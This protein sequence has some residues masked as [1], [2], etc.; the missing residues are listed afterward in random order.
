MRKFLLPVCMMALVVFATGAQ[1]ATNHAGVKLGMAIQDLGGDG[2]ESIDV[3]SR[4]GFVGGAY[5]QSDLSRNF[6]IRLEALYYMKGATGDSADIDVTVKLDYV[7]LP[8]LLMAHVPFSE[9]GRLS[10]FAGPTFSFNTNAEAEASF[11]GFTGSVDIGDAIKSFDFGLTFGAG[12]S[13]DVGSVILG[14]DGRYGFGLDTVIDADFVSDEGFTLD[15][16]DDV[17]NQGF[18]FMAQLGFPLGGSSE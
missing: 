13:F 18:A 10:L 8:L 5:F 3:E 4:N 17:K 12:M 6:G 15:E 2:L 1:A 16:D 9:T 14:F 11:A 7:E